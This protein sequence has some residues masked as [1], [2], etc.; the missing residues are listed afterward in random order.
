MPGR[1]LSLVVFIL[2]LALSTAGQ[3]TR[4]A[5]RPGDARP[6][7]KYPDDE[8]DA[9]RLPDDMRIKMAIARADEEH[10]K[11]VEDAEKLSKLADEIAKG[12]GEHKR[13][14]SDDFKKLGNIEKL[15]KRVLTH[16]GG[17]EVEPKT[18]PT[19]NMLLPQA[20][21]MLNSTAANIRKEMTAETRFVVSATVIANSNEVIS[22]CRFIKRPK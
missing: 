22:L 1:C 2:L 18:D 15:A 17:E 10:K 12:Y 20:I 8:Q 9:T 6:V 3:N 4:P 14:S 19:E 5:P 16:A 11:I 21:D 7:D 13:L